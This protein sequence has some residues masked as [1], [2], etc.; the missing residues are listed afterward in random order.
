[1]ADS[2]PNDEN[3][4]V[5]R[6]MQENGDDLTKP[7]DLEFTVVFPSKVFA[8][9]F[10]DHFRQLGYRVSIEETKCVPELPWDVV[11]ARN[12]IPLHTDIAEFEDTLSVFAAPLGG[13][14]DGWGCFTLPT[15]Q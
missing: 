7:R 13:R 11:V 4:G 2:F 9:A 14:N 10:A 5:L 1:M 8:E 3:G 12:M 15:R 6:R